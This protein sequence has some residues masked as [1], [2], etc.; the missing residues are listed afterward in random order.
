M[1]RCCASSATLPAKFDA[2]FASS[3]ALTVTGDG[4]RVG[5]ALS[6]PATPK[7][8]RMLEIARP[9]IYRGISRRARALRP[10]LKVLFMSGYSRTAVVHQG[11]VDGDVQLMQKPISSQDLAI[12]I[13]DL[14]DQAHAR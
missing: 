8:T 10:S 9:T 13:R 1:L 7:P 5:S 11:R 2:E 4:P 14:L 6:N 3:V 12:R